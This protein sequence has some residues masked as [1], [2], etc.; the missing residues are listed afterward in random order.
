[1]VYGFTLMPLTTMS[2]IV[3]MPTPPLRFL[4][5]SLPPSLP[6]FRVVT[7]HARSIHRHVHEGLFTFY[8]LYVISFTTGSTWRKVLGRKGGSDCPR[9][10][11]E[12][13]NNSMGHNS[14]DRLS[15]QKGLFAYTHMHTSADM[16]VY[17]CPL[18]TTHSHPY[19]HP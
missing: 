8:A 3:S 5:L 10:I 2:L 16:Y 14:L 7:V 4:S 15:C 6:S 11:L 19:T 17:S 13:C 18:P 1:M 9:G 12:E